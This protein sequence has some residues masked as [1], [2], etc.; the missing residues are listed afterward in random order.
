MEN[1]TINGERAPIQNP[2]RWSI[3]VAAFCAMV[4]GPSLVYAQDKE[5]P[6]RFMIRAGAL[7]LNDVDTIVRVD[8]ANAPVGT[9]LDFDRDLGGES[10]TTAARADL[11][12]RFNDRHAVTASWYKF[13][14]DGTRSIQD[15]IVI[16]NTT[17]PAGS[18]LT[19]SFSVDVV[20]LDYRYS[21]INT[22]EAE[23]GWTIGVHQTQL[24]FDINRPLTG[25]T[26]STDINGPLPVVGFFAAYNFT[27]RFAWFVD[28][29]LFFIDI[30][31]Q[32]GGAM[33]DFLFGFEFRVL[34]HVG[35]G[36]AFNRFRLEAEQDKESRDILYDYGFNAGYGYAAI[37]F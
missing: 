16:G 2:F 32:A 26:Q 35:L 15:D 4:F 12:F 19:S 18:G 31:D 28:Y 23:L 8:A 7:S 14:L 37:Y 29:E 27:P 34:R 10:S 11:G 3:L 1:T 17:F 33:Q 36:I 24:E 9:N 13:D 25:E 21:F 20:T 5:F 6:D 22:R 30:P